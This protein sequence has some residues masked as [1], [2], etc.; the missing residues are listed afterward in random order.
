V[1]VRRRH[2]DTDAAGELV[3]A[4]RRGALFGEELLRLLDEGFLQSP[5]VVAAPPGTRLLHVS[6]INSGRQAAARSV[7]GDNY[8]SFDALR[9]AFGPRLP[10]GAERLRRARYTLH[11]Q[12][13]GREAGARRGWAEIDAQDPA[14]GRYTGRFEVPAGGVVGHAQYIVQGPGGVVV[15]VPLK[16]DDGGPVAFRKA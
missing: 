5:V 12:T 13:P 7:T 8:F 15:V 10:D 2:A 3:Q 11:P 9:G 16:D 6:D 1:A 4:E 14:T